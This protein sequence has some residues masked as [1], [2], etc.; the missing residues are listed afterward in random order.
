MSGALGARGFGAQGMII[1]ALVFDSAI[2]VRIVLSE[3]YY[4]IIRIFTPIKLLTSENFFFM[5][6]ESHL[7][8]ITCYTCMDLKDYNAE[9][10]ESQN[11]HLCLPLPGNTIE[12][13]LP[14]PEERI[15]DLC[16]RM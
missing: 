1:F 4:S 3:Y 8:K 6:E 14:A 16:L 10:K 9:I 7:L 15:S 2:S 5:N 11:P 12:M 13:M